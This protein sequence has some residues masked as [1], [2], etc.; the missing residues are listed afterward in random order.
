MGKCLEVQIKWL[1]W[2]REA[3]G[4]HPMAMRGKFEIRTH[5]HLKGGRCY[6]RV[7][8]QF[9]GYK[10]DNF[11]IQ[12][13]TTADGMVFIRPLHRRT[14]LAKPVKVTLDDLRFALIGAIGK[15][16]ATLSRC[17]EYSYQDL[18]DE[19][20]SKSNADGESEDREHSMNIIRFSAS[21]PGA[22]GAA[23]TEWFNNSGKYSGKTTMDLSIKGYSTPVTVTYKTKKF[24]TRK[25][26]DR[27]RATLRLVSSIR[28][29]KEYTKALQ[30]DHLF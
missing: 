17:D 2:A 6:I 22:C 16:H 23:V 8:W 15:C 4:I 26:L 18:A 25:E 10:Y 1:E 7:E 28:T 5:R 11:N 12:M 13:V 29:L 24:N 14:A 3:A 19:R 20:V 9:C 21:E 30:L 27:Y